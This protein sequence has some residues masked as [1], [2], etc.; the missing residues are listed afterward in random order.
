MT[1]FLLSLLFTCSRLICARYVQKLGIN[2]GLKMLKLNR[3]CSP[4][5]L[6]RRELLKLLCYFNAGD[7]NLSLPNRLSSINV[8]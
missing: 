4:C 1:F 5:N 6:V 7:T 3:T 2:Y 8:L